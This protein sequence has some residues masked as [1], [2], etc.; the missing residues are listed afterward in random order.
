MVVAYGAVLFAADRLIQPVPVAAA[1]VGVGGLVGL[2]LASNRPA[3]Y[4]AV[5]MAT[6]LV[7]G[8]AQHWAVHRAG[9]SPEPLEG[10]GS[11]LLAEGALGLL[12][13]AAAVAAAAAVRRLT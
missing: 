3:R 6:G 1:A 4:V 2:W 9:A 7:I 5:G 10:L 8:T 12:V 13:G 11:H